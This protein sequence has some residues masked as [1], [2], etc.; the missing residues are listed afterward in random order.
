[1]AP[2]LAMRGVSSLEFLRR[3]GISSDFFQNPDIW[4]PQTACFRIGNEMADI[5][6][7]PFGGAYVGFLTEI[8]SL[9]AWG[10]SILGSENIAQACALAAS[11]SVLLHQAGKVKIVTE[12]R[13]TKLIHQFTGPCEADPRH[14]ILGSLAV[15]RKIPLM[16]GEP[17]AIRVHI[18]MPRAR[19]DDVLEECLGQNLETGA[20]YNMIEF[21]RDLLDSPLQHTRD[22]AWK[23]TEAIRSTLQTANTLITRISDRDQS[24]LATISRSV[25]L[26]PRTLQRRLNYCGVDFDALRDET[27]RLEALQL[28]SSGNYSATEIAYMVGYSDQAHFTRA[29]KRWTGSIPSRYRFTS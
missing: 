2:Y 1:M 19:G 13:T 16:S 26:S 27:R 7:D 9:G 14:F 3:L 29:F 24:K 28:I 15:L 10:E 22:N 17:S 6:Q 25:G 12:G 5:T 23:T 18:K 4:L 20:E 21:D 11:N 8:R